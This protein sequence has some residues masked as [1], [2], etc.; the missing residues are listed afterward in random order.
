MN[1][2][3]GIFEMIRKSASG[4]GQISYYTERTE[5]SEFE[6]Q[7]MTGNRCRSLLNMRC[8]FSA[9]GT[10]IFYAA[11]HCVR[12]D[13]ILKSGMADIYDILSLCSAFLE[14]LNIMRDFMLN[15]SDIPYDSDEYI[16]CQH[17]VP[18]LK[19]AYIPGYKNKMSVREKLSEIADTAIEYCITDDSGVRMLSDYKGRLYSVNDEIRP[20]MLLT[21]E[22]A[23][24][25]AHKDVEEKS[26]K[27]D[28]EG[29][30]VLHRA[31]TALKEESGIY[32]S[33]KGFKYWIKNLVD[34]LVS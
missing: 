22:E 30:A 4:S 16:F 29:A 14:T 23:R 11:D 18:G 1:D 8:V 3:G 25:C 13:A 17:R 26:T 2:Y 24:K 15:P 27:D 5:F 32:R 20:L 19:F 9:E 7:I 31:L 34:G 6:R 33:R 21:E 12:L 10:K 28:D